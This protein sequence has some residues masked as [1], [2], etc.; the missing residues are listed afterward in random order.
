MYFLDLYYLKNR[1]VSPNLFIYFS[2]NSSLSS[3]WHRFCGI[4]LFIFL[5]IFFIYFKLITNFYYNLVFFIIFLKFWFLY[6]FYLFFLFIFLYHFLNGIRFIS[7]NFITFLDKKHL[8]N[9]FI[10]WNLILFLFFII[11]LIT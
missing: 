11:E 5:F 10:L 6:F 2:Q 8:N 9:F 1:P 7:L 3:I 4:Y